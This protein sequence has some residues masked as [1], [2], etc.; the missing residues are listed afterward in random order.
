ME[1]IPSINHGTIGLLIIILISFVLISLVSAVSFKQVYNPFTRQL[2]YYR[3]GNFTGE[4]VTADYFFGDSA[5]FNDG[6]L[7]GGLSIIGGDI[8]AQVGYFY[9]ITSL[10]VTKQNLTIIGNLSLTGNVFSESLGD[11]YFLG[12]VGIGTASPYSGLHYQGDIFYL[13]PNAGAWSNDNITI[14]NYATSNATHSGAPNIILKTSDIIG[15][16][17]IGVGTLSLVGGSKTTLYG[18]IDG[19]GGKISLQGGRG[20]DAGNNPSSYA[21]ILLQSNGGNVGIG[22]TSPDRL[23]EV[24]GSAP[25]FRFRDS[26]ATAS[27][28]TAFIE[29]GGTDAA[30]WNR[31]GYIGDGSSGDTHIRLRA[32]DSDLYLGDSSGEQV[33]VLSGGDATFSGNVGIGTATPGV[34]LEVIGNMNL[35]GNLTLGE[36]ITFAFGEIIDNLVDGWITI[37]GS[38]N[39]TG[40]VTADNVFLLADIS[41]HTNVTIPVA[42]AGVWYNVTFDDG[43]STPVKD[44]LHTYNDGT[45]DTFTI[46]HTGTYEV[47]YTLTIA[48]SN[49]T[50]GTHVAVRLI[51]NGVEIDGSL[52]EEDSTRQYAEFTIGNGPHVDL[53][54]GDE[55]KLQFTAGDTTVNMEGH[56]TY[57]DHK[58]SATLKMV[59]IR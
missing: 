43:V 27:A 19:G 28:T 10:N 5:E 40:N 56:Q 36:K 15:A 39:V 51:K 13:T 30:A 52:I 24:F 49:P 16:Y 53:I 34:K 32:E 7:N 2:D 37:T 47:R 8:Y 45:N 22:T 33:L 54:K 44:I 12:N 55:I 29:F 26:G 31:T 14:K 59:R 20:R 3:T 41:A 21:P 1:K 25:I 23:F 48:D 57:G 58:D 6:W 50:P 17:G 9:N 46:I 18:G 11:N 35:T 42:I 38:L 4:N